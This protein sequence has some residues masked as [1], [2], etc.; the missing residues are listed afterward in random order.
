MKMF[1]SRWKRTF[2]WVLVIA[3]IVSG[4]YRPIIA[5]DLKQEPDVVVE[6]T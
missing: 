4:K 3:G 5:D 2:I 1:L 6:A